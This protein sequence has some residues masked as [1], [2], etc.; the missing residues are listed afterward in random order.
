MKVRDKYFDEFL[1]CPSQRRNT[2]DYEFF[3]VF[4]FSNAIFGSGLCE[5]PSRASVGGPLRLEQWA[6]SVSITSFISL[7]GDYV[8]SGGV[9]F[10]HL[11]KWR[12]VVRGT[13]YKNQLVSRRI[14][15]CPF[16][17]SRAY[18]QI[19]LIFKRIEIFAGSLWRQIH[20]KLET[21]FILQ[22]LAQNMG[23]YF[24]ENLNFF[25]HSKILITRRIQVRLV[26]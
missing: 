21:I 19:L 5:P 25:F 12:V 2:L 1:G 20:I 11:A 26:T 16:N 14:S 7:G 4:L 6:H 22:Q 10:F 17:G 8:N 15:L 18:Q 13:I 9:C 23:R 24:S 3:F